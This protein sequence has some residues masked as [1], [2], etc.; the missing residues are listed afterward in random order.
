MNTFIK[1]TG[2]KKNISKL[3][4]SHIK[5][6]KTKYIEPF[7][8][9]G[10]MFFEILNNKNLPFKEYHINDFNKN[11]INIYLSLKN[12]Y[13]ELYNSYLENYNI[14]NS[15]FYHKDIFENRKIFFNILKQK[16]NSDK[17]DF[18]L[19]YSLTRFSYNGMIRYNQKGD[20]NSSCHFTRSGMEPIKVKKL[21]NEHYNLLNNKN[22]IITNTSYEN[23]QYDEN[24]FTYLDPPYINSK[25]LYYGN[26]NNNEFISYIK[27]LNQEKIE[28]ILSYD[29][30][31]ESD[32][33]N[34]ILIKE[35][36]SSF[37][38]LKNV[39]NNLTK[40]FIFTNIKQNN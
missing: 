40:E 36:S 9:G 2:S 27:K 16:F 33:L 1:W 7:V 5:T 6:N 14:F 10:S 21:L 8:G 13:N 24:S 30:N 22:I 37:K 38:R 3:I 15:D 31:Y 34:K 17:N 29:S 20:Y 25:E 4:S 35:Y 12:N 23:L 18:I 11:L 39:D 28:L 19:F 32:F 26:F